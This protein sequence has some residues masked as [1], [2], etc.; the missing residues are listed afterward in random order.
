MFEVGG[1]Y[2]VEGRAIANTA[3]VRATPGSQGFSRKT[4]VHDERLG[5]FLR[6][7]RLTAS[8]LR[9]DR[10]PEF[11]TAERREGSQRF[12]AATLSYEPGLGASAQ[13]TWH[14]PR[15][16]VEVGMGR[17]VGGPDVDRGPSAVPEAQGS[18][19]GHAAGRIR[20]W[21]ALSLGVE[22][23]SV[24]LEGAPIPDEP[25]N[26]SDV[27][28]RQMAATV[29]W[30]KDIGV[31]TVGLRAGTA[32]KST[33]LIQTVRHP[34]VDGRVGEVK[35]DATYPAARGG[36]L[37]GAQFFPHLERHVAIGLDLTYHRFARVTGMP[38]LLKPSY[39][40]AVILIQ[41]RSN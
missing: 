23:G 11:A 13:Q 18:V 33:A 22:I 35:T 39:L 3:L 9:V 15:V 20:A 26:R 24:S 17:S 31:G 32:F 25:E 29:G 41:M 8:Y 16:Q 36:L 27:M 30:T 21:R 37:L 12:G 2:G 28:L 14:H 6:V 10:S 38:G 5:G 7:G 4:W 40:K 1:L 34:L 19:T